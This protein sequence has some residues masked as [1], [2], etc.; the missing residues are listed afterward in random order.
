MLVW[1]RARKLQ[2]LTW[3]VV[4]EH[5]SAGGSQVLSRM[6][7]SPDCEPLPFGA[8][9]TV[10]FLPGISSVCGHLGNNLCSILNHP[11]FQAHRSCRRGGGVICF[12]IAYFSGCYYNS[13]PSDWCQAHPQ[14]KATD[15]LFLDFSHVWNSL[16]S[17][18]F[19]QFNEILSQCPV[20]GCLHLGLLTARSCL[21]LGTPTELLELF[22]MNSL[23]IRSPPPLKA[24]TLT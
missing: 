1:G 9:I 7:R 14:M 12:F 24:A 19:V 10:F 15:W 8:A 21:R 6:E 11:L 18:V 20:R 4:T 23:R 13:G 22:S 3:L 5:L 2:R 16:I 17:A